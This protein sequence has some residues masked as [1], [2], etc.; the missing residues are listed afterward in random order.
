MQEEFHNA[1]ALLLYVFMVHRVKYKIFNV[2][3]EYE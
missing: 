2:S 1:A 3:F